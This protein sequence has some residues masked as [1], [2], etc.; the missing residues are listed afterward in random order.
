[1]GNASFYTN[2]ASVGTATNG[3]VVTAPAIDTGGSPTSFY[4]DAGVLTSLQEANFTVAVSVGGSTL[5]SNEWLGAYTFDFVGTFA[6]NL[7]GSQANAGA[8]STGTAVIALLRNG[9]QFATLTFTSGQS[10][11]T[12]LGPQTTF[13]VGDVLELI[14]P[15][16]IDPTLAHLAISLIGSRVT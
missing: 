5:S 1:M 4:K 7:Q 6:A 9:T 8:T 13:Q 2:N 15:S 11:G 16:T 10:A 3:S 12:F 14:A